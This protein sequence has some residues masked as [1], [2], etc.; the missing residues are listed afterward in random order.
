MQ[1][2]LKKTFKFVHEP[3]SVQERAIPF[4]AH[5]PEIDMLKERIL[6]S[7]GGTF[8]LTGFRGA[9]KTTVVQ[10]ALEELLQSAAK[11][12]LIIPIKINFA[13]PI[14]HKQLLFEIIRRLFEALIDRRVLDKIDPEIAQ[15]MTLSYARTSL[16][17]KRSQS[18]SLEEMTT[19]AWGGDGGKASGLSLV[20]LLGS[21]LPKLTLSRKKISSLASEASFLAY[22]DTDVEHD[23]L[24][25]VSLLKKGY[26]RK[27]GFWQK[28]Q[29]FFGAGGHRG[30][31]IVPKLVV[32]IDELDKLA[33]LE[34]GLSALDYVL[35]GM[36][37]ILTT[38]GVC[39]IF[40]GGPDLHDQWLRDIRKG[41]S[42]YESTF[43][44]QTYIPCTWNAAEKFIEHVK[45]ESTTVNAERIPLFVDYLNYKGRGIPRRLVQEFN[46]FVQW[47]NV[48]TVRCLDPDVERITFYAQLQRIL[49]DLRNHTGI[50]TSFNESSIG[51]DRQR[52]GTYYVLDWVL[53]SGG[54]SFLAKD[55]LAPDQTNII[56]PSL[57]LSRNAVERVLQHLHNHAVLEDARGQA[58]E[59][60][61]IGDVPVASE[62]LYRL[63]DDVWERMS[64]VVLSSE[65]ER[66]DLKFAPIAEEAPEHAAGKAL[67]KS[68]SKHAREN[69]LQQFSDLKEIGR[70]GMGIVY[71]ATDNRNGQARALKFLAHQWRDNQNAI[72][73]FVRE[74]QIA[75]KLQHPNFVKTYDILQLDDQAPILVMEL[76]RGQSLRALITEHVVTPQQAVSYMLQICDAVAF[77]H[78]NGIHRL[79]IKPSNLIIE[80]DGRA[81]VIDLGI[82]RLLNE[83]SD[84]DELTKTGVVVGT[85]TYGAPEQ[86]TGKRIDERADIYSIGI[87]LFEIL[88]GSLP[89]SDK[90]QMAVLYD[91]TSKDLDTSGLNASDELKKVVAKAT[92][93]NPDERYQKASDLLTAL[94]KVPEASASAPASDDT[95]VAPA[96][97]TSASK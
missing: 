19:T 56:D 29:Q 8:L 66:A 96:P 82:A 90:D 15:A 68:L 32:V 22:T 39:F 28:L 2:N 75:G 47:R 35:N 86:I 88:A 71:S 64:R 5:Q 70:G 97:P 69:I 77:A 20:S 74:S 18:Q 84:E 41:N 60:T 95:A 92:R 63:A 26:Q 25:I 12:E 38:S 46:S 24:R 89:W 91:I 37:N 50:E 85:L 81:V 83:A 6:N 48:P 62:R 30:E 76:V 87:V 45:D 94:Q 72:E 57:K 16:S 17:I 1:F 14:E 65:K 73:R 34:N 67:P 43:A 31:T 33:Q 36:K 79:D 93:R 61:V 42:I 21:L 51:A 40:I 55:V 10:R 58:N 80:P 4:L 9:G 44:W 52:L 3:L 49:S 11:N 27:L 78:Q 7:L 54:R 13:R 23:F 59:Q 53:G